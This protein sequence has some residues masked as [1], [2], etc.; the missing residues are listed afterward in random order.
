M[1]ADARDAVRGPKAAVDCPP[2][3]AEGPGAASH[4]QTQKPGGRPTLLG[5]VFACE[6]RGVAVVVQGKARENAHGPLD[7]VRERVFGRSVWAAVGWRVGGKR[8]RLLSFALTPA[9]PS[10][11]RLSP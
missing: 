4:G 3:G 6:W 1:K 10:T 7:Q 8:V 5:A 2:P 9:T 11:P